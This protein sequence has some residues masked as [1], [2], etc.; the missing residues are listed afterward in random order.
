VICAPLHF[1]RVRWIFRRVYETHSVK[2]RFRLAPVAPTPGAV[3]WELGALPV[4]ARQ[5]RAAQT[6]LERS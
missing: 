6:E 5:L 3:A 4:M 1:F 2:V